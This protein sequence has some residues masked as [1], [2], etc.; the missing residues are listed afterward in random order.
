VDNET[1]VIDAGAVTIAL[2]YRDETMSD[3]GLGIQVFGEADGKNT[4]ILRF[5][6]FDHR[7]HYHYG[8]ENLN[9]RQDMDQTTT[10]NT[11]GW[12]IKQLELR[13]PEMIERAGYDDLAAKVRSNPVPQA[14][15]MEAETKGRELARTGRR[16]VAHQFERLLEKDIFVAGNIRFMLEYRILPQINSEG[17]AIHVMS[18]V[19]DQ[20]VEIL[21]FD[22][23][24]DGPHYHYGP[25][26]LDM[27][28]Y[29]DT[30]ITPEKETLRW[31][32]EQFKAGNLRK[33]IDRAGYPAIANALDE[34]L[35]Q[36]MMPAIEKR[37]YELVAENNTAQA[38]PSD[39]KRTKAQLIEELEDLR[40]QVAAL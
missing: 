26:N 38:V 31:T 15:L 28:I 1:T 10:G 35:V 22:C 14:A 40:K 20:N 33:M 39:G 37:S 25:R 2:R 29:W 21:A 6:C 16:T 19:A 24:D 4:E 12:T 30:T 34:N 3:Q 11:L 36:S 9:I 17:M 7:P 8:P 18:D 32:L 27:R 13:L 5:D 23:F